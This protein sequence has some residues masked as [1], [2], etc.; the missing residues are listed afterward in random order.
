MLYSVGLNFSKSKREKS[1][2]K[3]SMYRISVQLEWTEQQPKKKRKKFG[4]SEKK[5]KLEQYGELQ[6]YNHICYIYTY[7]KKHHIIF[8]INWVVA[9]HWKCIS[10]RHINMLYTILIMIIMKSQKNFVGPKKKKKKKCIICLIKIMSFWS[11]VHKIKYFWV[12][13]S[14]NHEAA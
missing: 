12:I 10:P 2:I 9:F 1:K 7:L 13:L 5:T 8:K 6:K 11:C 3:I 4:D 14:N